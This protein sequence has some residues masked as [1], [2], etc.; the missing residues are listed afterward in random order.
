MSNAFEILFAKLNGKEQS[1][2]T[3]SENKEDVLD[4]SNSDDDSSEEIEEGAEE[5]GDEDNDKDKVITSH[6]VR[7]VEDLGDDEY[8]SQCNR[9]L[10]ANCTKR[11][12]KTGCMDWTKRLS[13]NGY[14][15]TSFLGR[16]RFAHTVAWELKNRKSIPPNNLVRHLC[17]VANRKCINPD[18]L[19]IGTHADNTQDSIN[20]GTFPRGE[21]HY[22]AKITEEQAR[23][24]IK[25]INNGDSVEKRAA[26]IG[27]SVRMVN[28]IDR[29][30]SWRHLMTE[31]D[32]SKRRRCQ[33]K[34]YITRDL[35]R[36]I[37]ASYGVGSI[38]ERA[39]RFGVEYNTVYKIDAKIN[40]KDVDVDEKKD[41][42]VQKQKQTA[43]VER[44]KVRVKKRSVIWKDEKGKLHWLQDG[45]KSMDEPAKRVLTTY[46]GKDRH[47]YVMSYLAFNQLQHPPVGKLIRHKCRYKYCLNPDHLET[48]THQDNADDRARDGT[49]PTGDKHKSS[50]LTDAEVMEIYSS[51]DN[52]S[53]IEMAKKYKVH[54]D[55]ISSIRK[56]KRK[57]STGE[58]VAE[59]S[60]KKQKL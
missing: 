42:E 21:T 38:T 30:V 50:K 17:P 9:I 10:V 46:F 51:K 8:K 32:L 23:K 16:R 12:G 55:T 31:E 3:N 2:I 58:T 27:V 35:A 48:G 28:E 41:L 19:A 26:D 33:N 40:W 36:M 39:K 56:G 24:I 34:K 37:K 1:V 45:N 43:R 13:G 14:G 47:W 15:K 59:A 44:A 49:I 60:K 22:N 6:S 25:T 11:D 54:C 7:K 4:E 20:A 5:S 53:R 52:T 18:H 57:I 29:G